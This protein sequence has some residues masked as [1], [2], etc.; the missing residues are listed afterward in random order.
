MSSGCI[1]ILLMIPIGFALWGYARV[2]LWGW[3]SVPLGLPSL[4]F[5]WS[6]GIGALISAFTYRTPTTADQ[7]TENVVSRVFTSTIVAPLIAMAAGWLALW[8]G[9]QP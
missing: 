1:A 7:S 5:W 6:V 9:G 4:T 8:L 3:F 2:V